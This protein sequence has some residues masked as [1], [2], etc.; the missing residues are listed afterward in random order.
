[1]WNV[2]FQQQMSQS[3]VLFWDQ[4]CGFFQKILLDYVGSADS[5]CKNGIV[6]ELRPALQL[7]TADKLNGGGAGCVCQSTD[8]IVTQ[9][10]YVKKLQ[11]TIAAAVIGLH[12]KP[13]L[14]LVI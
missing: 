10:L 11:T 4:K 8:L 6:P 7:L 14:G 9:E 5:T 12:Q 2:T 1:M 13:G 3:T